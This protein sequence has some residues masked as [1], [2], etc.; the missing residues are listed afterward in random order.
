MS[1][2][3]EEKNFANMIT[4]RILRWGYYPELSSWVLIAITSVFM[5]G[6]HKESHMTMETEFGVMCFK[7]EKGAT[8]QGIPAATRN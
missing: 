3:L 8:R 4:L 7:M 1:V 6:R 2:T 5:R